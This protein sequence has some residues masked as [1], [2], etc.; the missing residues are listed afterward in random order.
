MPTSSEAAR[1]VFDF[2]SAQ[3][4][5]QKLTQ[6]IEKQSDADWTWPYSAEREPEAKDRFTVL[7]RCA[8]HLY[9]HIGQINYLSRELTKR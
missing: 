7:L 4:A 3:R 2:Q 1:A 9:H 8:V 5:K 6:R